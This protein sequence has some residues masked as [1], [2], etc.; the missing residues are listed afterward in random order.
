MKPQRRM[1]PRNLLGLLLGWLL[2]LPAPIH[3]QPVVTPGATNAFIAPTNS[4]PV[5]T[6]IQRIVGLGNAGVSQTQ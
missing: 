4:L 2:T 3:A 1:V 6:S 5:L